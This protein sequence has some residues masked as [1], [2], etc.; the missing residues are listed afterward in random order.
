VRRR[1]T[2]VLSAALIT[3]LG[4]GAAAVAGAPKALAEN[5]GGASPLILGV[6]L[7]HLNPADLSLLKNTAVLAV[8]QDSIAARRVV[9]A[10]TRQAFAKKEQGGDV[11]VGLF[12]TGGKAQ[13]VSVAPSAVG[14][15][16][17]ARYVL[18]NLWTHQGS[19]A[20]GISATVP[21]RGVVLYRVTTR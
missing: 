8:D 9:N 4:L 5:N 18:D 20:S 15:P 19:T 2:A 10:S 13:Q 17:G 21:A 12:N 16:A 3:G 11:I 7:T 14:L 6:D 1:L